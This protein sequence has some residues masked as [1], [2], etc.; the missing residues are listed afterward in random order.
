MNDPVKRKASDEPIT[1]S[2]KP[3]IDFEHKKIKLSTTSSPPNE[4]KEKKH[5]A[6]PVGGEPPNKVRKKITWP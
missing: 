2:D 1:A 3:V 5:K 4:M 6:D